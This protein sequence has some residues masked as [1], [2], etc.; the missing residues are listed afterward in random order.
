MVVER[1]S[2]FPEEKSYTLSNAAIPD[3]LT[4]LVFEQML[5]S[6]HQQ[7]SIDIIDAKGNITPTLISKAI[8]QQ[9]GDDQLIIQ[10]MGSDRT[11]NIFFD[12]DMKIEKIVWPD[13]TILRTTAEIIAE[14]FPRQAELLL[15]STILK[16]MEK[17][18]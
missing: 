8:S 2:R 14:Q 9:T 3:I 7:V 11:A 16:E 4:D 10:F 6:G 17:Q 5:L 1:L 18:F 13:K 15:R 12:E